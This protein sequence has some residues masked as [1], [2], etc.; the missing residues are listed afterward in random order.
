MKT[1]RLPVSLNNKQHLSVTRLA[2]KYS[3]SRSEI[4]RIGLLLLADQER[5]GF[6]I[7]LLKKKK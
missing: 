6:E 4:L 3:K 2:K 5:V 1:A 7:P